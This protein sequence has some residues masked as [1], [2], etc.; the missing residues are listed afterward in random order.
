VAINKKF[1]I[2]GVL[3]LLSSFSPVIFCYDLDIRSLRTTLSKPDTTHTLTYQNKLPPTE[4]STFILQPTNN[5]QI[6]LFF[7]VNGIEIGYS[8]DAVNNHTE[9]KTQNI[10][11][12]YRKLNDSKVTLNLQ[13]L[14]GL[15]SSY[16]NHHTNET[17]LRFLENSS[18]TKFELL[19]QHHLYT[20]DDKNSLFNHFFLNRP[21]LSSKFDWA[22][23]VAAGWSIKR[24]ILEN[25]NSILFTPDF[26]QQTIPNINSLTSNSFS[27]D[28]GPFLSVN[29]AHNLHAF[30]EIKMGVGYIENTS[31]HTKLKISG[32]ETSKAYGAGLSW[33]SSNKQWLVLLRSW[34]QSGRHITTTFG[35]LSIIKFF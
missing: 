24:L 9:T 29:L 6:G 16:I 27:V 33:T 20:W 7:D 18:S 22:L 1:I 30:A 23:S 2:T 28:I 14:E 12:S 8:I 5:E 19:G 34:Q 3:S 11:L 13:K 26:I 35:D 17:S 4:K 10:L 32:K 31:G 25:E 21:Q 15:E